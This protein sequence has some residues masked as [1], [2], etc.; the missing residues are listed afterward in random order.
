MHAV[1]D[2]DRQ[3][4]DLGREQAN[5]T[6]KRLSELVKHIR[7]KTPKDDNGNQPPLT[8]NL[9]KSTMTRATQTANIILKHFPEVTEH[10]SDDLI[11]EGAPCP[12]DPPFP[13]WDPSPS[14][15]VNGC[16]MFIYCLFP[17]QSCFA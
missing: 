3:L 17:L 13:E 5:I 8:L 7:N 6:G 15:R 11:R 14:V 9:V 12:P 1:Q 4:T 2:V 16:L 10:Q